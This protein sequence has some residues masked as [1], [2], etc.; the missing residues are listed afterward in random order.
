[1]CSLQGEKIGGEKVLYYYIPH[2]ALMMCAQIDNDDIAFTRDDFVCLGDTF[3]C[4]GEF[5]CILDDFTHT[6]SVFVAPRMCIL[7]DFAHIGLT[8]DDYCSHRA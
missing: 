2:Y 8:R 3:S 6:G 7:D 4:N 5:A 1:M